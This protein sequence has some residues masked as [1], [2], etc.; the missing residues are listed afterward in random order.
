MAARSR[1][2]IEG[3]GLGIRLE[4]LTAQGHNDRGAVRDDADRDRDSSA[5]P[6]PQEREQGETPTEQAPWKGE[7]GMAIT[8]GLPT[9]LKPHEGL[10][11]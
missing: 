2:L 6:P 5:T 4:H 11:A 10:M 9:A 3:Q 1:V 8:N 7:R